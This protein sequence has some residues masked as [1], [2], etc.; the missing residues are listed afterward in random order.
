MFLRLWHNDALHT[1]SVFLARTREAASFRVI[2]VRYKSIF[3]TF[4][5][6]CATRL[7]SSIYKI[8]RRTFIQTSCANDRSKKSLKTKKNDKR[9]AYYA[10]RRIPRLVGGRR[11]RIRSFIASSEK[12]ASARERACSRLLTAPLSISP[13]RDGRRFFARRASSSC[14]SRAVITR[15]YDRYTAISA[16]RELSAL[17]YSTPITWLSIRRKKRSTTD[18]YSAVREKHST[19]VCH[20][21]NSCRRHKHVHS[22]IICWFRESSSRHPASPIDSTCRYTAYSVCNKEM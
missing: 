12:D 20:V 15:L 3:Q 13:L 18:N 22:V 21:E 17:M 11:V 1:S 6:V 19:R 14:L 7:P 10:L 4:S 16:L 9:H 8:C 5:Y 2:N